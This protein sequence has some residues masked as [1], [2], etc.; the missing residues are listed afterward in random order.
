MGLKCHLAEYLK[1]STNK[2]VASRCFARTLS[3]IR[4]IVIIC[5]VVDRFSPQTILISPKNFHKSRFDGVEWQSVVNLS[6]YGSI[7]LENI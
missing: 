1:K 7:P 6:R 4:R 5:Y 3:R 2:S